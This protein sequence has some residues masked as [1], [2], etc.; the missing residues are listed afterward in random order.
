MTVT[1]ESA[2]LGTLTA[3]TTFQTKAPPKPKA[4]AKS[5]PKPDARKGGPKKGNDAPPAE[6]PDQKQGQTPGANTQKA[7]PKK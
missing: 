3:T 1:Q 7:R 6:T 2:L 5:T 4:E